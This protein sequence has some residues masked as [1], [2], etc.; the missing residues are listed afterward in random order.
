MKPE[1]LSVLIV[2][3]EPEA[4][5]LLTIILDRMEGIEITAA[6]EGV[7]D[8]Y[9]KILK[10]KPDLIL[11]DIQMPKK[12]GFELVKMTNSLKMDIGYI[13][14]TAYDHYALKALRSSAFDYLLKPADPDELEKAIRRFRSET[15][16]GSIRDQLQQLLTDLGNR[17][18]LK[19]R[20]RTG[21]III[22]PDE[23]THCRA[24]GN[25]T[26]VH[27]CSGR[28]ET[29]TNNLGNF[30]ES[31]PRG[32]FFRISRSV[33]INLK[34]LS[35]VDNR[36]GTCRLKDS[37]PVLLKVAR[38]HRKELERICNELNIQG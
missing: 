38:N 18:R 27:L 33:M 17:S 11:L 25:Y 34:Y 24:G 31:L 35:Q 15:K 19:I 14:V 8:A 23:I 20:T 22:D 16:K 6:A 2:D 3:D 13:F 21:F 9:S 29:I 26:D 5:D 10:K 7:D 36:S 28:T 1:L 30:M 32:S 4:R 37:T 12:D